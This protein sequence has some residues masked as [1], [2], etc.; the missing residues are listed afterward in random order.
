MEQIKKYIE[1]NSGLWNAAFG[2]N[3]DQLHNAALNQFKA[4]PSYHTFFGRNTKP[5]IEL[6]D[7][8]LRNSPIRDGKVFFTNSGSEA[9]ESVVK[10]LWMINRSIGLSDRRKLIA[11]KNGYHG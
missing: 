9:N 2:F 1:G 6:A 8:L 3:N 5:S 11:R 10:I 7:Q 4:L